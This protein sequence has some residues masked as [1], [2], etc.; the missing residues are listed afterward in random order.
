MKCLSKRRTVSPLWVVA[1]CICY[2]T[3]HQ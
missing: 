2:C 1:K 3:P